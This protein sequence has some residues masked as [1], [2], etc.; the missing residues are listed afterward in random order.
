MTLLTA[1]RILIGTSVA[2]FAFY[3]G[4]ELT[5]GGGAG[6]GGMLRGAAAA[7]AAIGLGIYFR[8]LKP[9]APARRTEARE[10]DHGQAL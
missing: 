6:G 9:Q 4:W 10:E 2:F 7:V 8:T 3:S 5:R 1:H